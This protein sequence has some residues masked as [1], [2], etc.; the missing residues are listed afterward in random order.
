MICRSVDARGLGGCSPQPA[1]PARLIPQLIRRGAHHDGGITG[2]LALGMRDARLPWVEGGP[3]RRRPRL[4]DEPNG[5]VT[6]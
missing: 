3:R 5:A 4:T 1:P 6:C 2:M